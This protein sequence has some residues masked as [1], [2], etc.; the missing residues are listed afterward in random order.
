MKPLLSDSKL[1]M[2]LREGDEA[3]FRKIYERYSPHVVDYVS[4]KLASL[5]DARGIV[6][7]ILKIMKHFMGLNSLQILGLVMVLGFQALP[8]VA[9]GSMAGPADSTTYVYKQVDG[10][11][12]T[13]DVY[14]PAVAHREGP[15]PAIILFHGG[16]W[17]A[18]NR[19]QMRYQCHY[20]AARGLVAITADYRL[21]EKKASLSDPRRRL[22]LMD[23]KSAIRWVKDHADLLGVDTGKIILG[24]GSAGGQLATMA[25]LNSRLN[26]PT[27]DTALST[28]AAA[29]V[30]FNPAYQRSDDAALEPFEFISSSCPPAIMFFGSDD[31]W[32]QPADTVYHQL[33]DAGVRAQLWVAPGQRHAFFNK[34]GWNQATCHEAA[35]FLH[36]LGFGK[37]DTLAFPSGFVL[38]AEPAVPAANP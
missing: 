15:A 6:H 10:Q 28:A 12:L 5:E 21:L 34:K 7:D 35:I 24:G 1:V 4:G 9:L 16:A 22:C 30:L 11:E 20:F 38:Q 33:L 2:H 31:H 27:D 23:A 14:Q 26:D 37:G 32:K 36:T 3:S 8:V 29:L 17:K 19:H 25:A 18:G 13:L